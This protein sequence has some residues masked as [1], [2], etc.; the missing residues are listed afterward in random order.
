M[1]IANLIFPKKRKANI[2][3]FDESIFLNLPMNYSEL[4][5]LFEDNHFIA[6]NKP[7]GVLVQPDKGTDAS[8]E[9]LV[10][11]YIKHQYNKPGEVFL[12]VCHRIDR[13]VSGVVIMARTSKA[14]VRMNEMFK[15]KEVKKTYWAVVEN[16][17]A[18]TEGT[19]IHWLK[20]DEKKNLSRVWD[21]E[22]PGTLRCELHYKWL[23]S[24][25]HY[26]LLEINPLT[27]RH[28]QIRA[29]LSAIGCAIKGDV[30]YHAKRGNRDGSIHLH[31]R[32]VEFIH[33]VKKEPIEI[34][35]PV[36]VDNVWK[37]VSTV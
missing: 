22:V 25:D 24:I 21:K 20:K 36:P 3:R 16:L 8:L 23:K 37:A 33:P 28:H 34:T 18:E 1:C 7:A 26:H 12:G 4:E 10:K 15:T 6:V 35:A 2:F 32:K 29:Q 14:L 27:G 5:I 19:L 11:E 30:K 31:A 13:P 9:V 17:P